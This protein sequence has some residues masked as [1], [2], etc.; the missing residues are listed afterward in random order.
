M[1]FN[2]DKKTKSCNQKFRVHKQY[3]R[4]KNKTTENVCAHVPNDEVVAL[5]MKEQPKIQWKIKEI[6]GQMIEQAI[7]RNGDPY[8]KIVWEKVHYHHWSRK[9]KEIKMLMQCLSMSMEYW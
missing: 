7:H 3:Y 2:P 6:N 4:G 8:D 1:L 5:R 9:R